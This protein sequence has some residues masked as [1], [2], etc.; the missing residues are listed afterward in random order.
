MSF[1]L[2][3]DYN[4]ADVKID[5]ELVEEE[6]LEQIQEMIDHEAFKGD[7]DVAIMPDTHWGAGAVIGFTMPLKN[8]VCPNTI[9][10]DIG[11][12]IYAAKVA[13]STMSLEDEET[14]EE[15]DEKIRERIPM[16]FNTHDR[17][18]YHME[19]DFPWEKCQEKVEKFNENSELPDV[20]V[21]YGPEY[22][23]NML[24]RIGY[25]TGRA[26][27]SVGTLGGGNHFIEIGVSQDTGDVWCII[28]SGSRGVGARIAEYWQDK[29]TELRKIERIREEVEGLANRGPESSYSLLQ[30]VKFSPED[31]NEEI[32]DWLNGAKGESFKKN[33][34]IRED[35]EGEEIEEVHDTLRNIMPDKQESKN[36]D[37]DYLE[38][39]EA[40]GYVRDMI[41][42]QT[43]ASESR[44]QM[45]Y[46]VMK[47]VDDVEGK[48][49]GEGL[50]DALKN[51]ERIESVHNYI[52]FTDQTIRKGACSAH[53]GEKIVIPFNMNYGTLIAEGKGKEDWNGSAPHGA[54]RAMSRTAAKEQYDAKD[55]KEQTEGV[56]MSKNPVDE[57][58]KAYKDPEVVEEAVG[59]TAEVVD[60]IVPKLSLKAE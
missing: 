16:G 3:G 32:L 25:D 51:Q 55:M 56:Y 40:T 12:G 14:L 18:D 29:A 26:I 45:M 19:N 54:G 9:G 8:R 28:H 36:T 27:N 10:V 44:K 38:G 48:T 24:E 4:T 7:N 22:F 50:V 11:C 5:K 39:E 30:Y 17:T 37:L 15:L 6:C 13:G 1:T 35:F 34:K 49:H 21:E 46:Q 42:A 43:Y 59:E 52:D 58:P 31:S 60:R 23:H 57:T 20:E 47:S 41:F 33:E 53:V 2:Q